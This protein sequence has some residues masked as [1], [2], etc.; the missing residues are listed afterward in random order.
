[1]ALENDHI[2][3]E[4]VIRLKRG[5]KQAFQELYS[6]FAP[7]IFRFALNWLKNRADAEELLQE[8]FLKLW[9]KKEYLDPDQNIRSYIFKIAVN[10]IYDFVRKK[11]LERAFSDYTKNNFSDFNEKTWHEVIWNDMVAKLNH[12]VSVLPEQQRKI[13]RMSREDGLSND[14][15]AEK[16]NLSKRTVENQL[17]R[18]MLYLKK[19]F[20]TESLIVLL[21][22]SLYS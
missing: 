5:D 21:F 9:E 3:Q 15:I 10:T 17:Y 8:V 19:Q 16:L 12:L 20:K 18:A 22:I 6:G 4:F 2:G 1:M 7:K 11:N 14:Q 13:F